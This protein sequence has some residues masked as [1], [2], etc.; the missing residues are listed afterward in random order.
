MTSFKAIIYMESWRIY[1]GGW[2]YDNFRYILCFS[3]SFEIFKNLIELLLS[4]LD[5]GLSYGLR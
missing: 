1:T 4:S 2:K 5:M 3:L